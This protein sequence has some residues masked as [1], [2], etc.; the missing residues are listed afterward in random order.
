MQVKGNQLS[1][2]L[3]NALPRIQMALAQMALLRG[4]RIDKEQLSLYSRRLA[5]ENPE[6]VIAAIETIQDLPREDGD[7]AFPEVGQILAVTGVQAAARHSRELAA[8]NKILAMWKC[9]H[10]GTV[11][12][13]FISPLD[14]EPRVCRGIPK[15]GEK[16]Q[17]CGEIMEQHYREGA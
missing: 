7:L 10:C 13:G 14:R 5:K 2:P 16:D 17:I 8:Q 12:S 3:D 1:K 4:T 11:T 15:V 6:D 9:P